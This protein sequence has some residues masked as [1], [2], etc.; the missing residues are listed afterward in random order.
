MKRAKKIARYILDPNGDLPKLL[1]MFLGS[2]IPVWA[3]FWSLFLDGDILA[4][5]IVNPERVLSMEE[6]MAIL[7]PVIFST[8]LVPFGAI[9]RSERFVRFVLSFGASPL[10]GILL[11]FSFITGGWTMFAGSIL[12][13]GILMA[14]W[15][16]GFLSRDFRMKLAETLK[17]I[18]G[19]EPALN[20]LLHGIGR[21]RYFRLVEAIHDAVTCPEGD[22]SIDI[23]NL[24]VAVIYG[25]W[26][27]R[28]KQQATIWSQI[29][30][31]YLQGLTKGKL[32]YRQR[33]GIL[34][35]AREEL[36][37][38]FE[39]FERWRDQEPPATA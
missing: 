20:T 2:L 8:L 19:D 35:K 22:E 25:P 32:A 38:R 4:A 24:D 9:D 16:C 17:G 31:I 21:K 28:R 1:L 39:E 11:R 29:E 6:L 26:R 7:V 5:I 30:R 18:S 13:I 14:F 37:A 36:E 12:S 15:K 10:L 33:Q 3:T 34:R 27:V 23:F